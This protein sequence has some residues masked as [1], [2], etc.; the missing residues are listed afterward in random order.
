MIGTG[1]KG[2]DR[3]GPQLIYRSKNLLW[4]TAFSSYA[5]GLICNRVFR[6]Y[7][8]GRFV[9]GGLKQDSRCS[10]SGSCG[11]IRRSIAGSSTVK[12]LIDRWYL[13][14]YS[15]SGWLEK[16][17]AKDVLKSRHCSL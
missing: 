12:V 3:A 10:N 7:Y 16:Q 15:G 13:C 9:F 2:A 5:F 8:F 14:F 17:G 4:G 6:H 11:I 1:L